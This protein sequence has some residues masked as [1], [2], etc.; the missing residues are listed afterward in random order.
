VKIFHG[1]PF[2]RVPAEIITPEIEGEIARATAQPAGQRS[3]RIQFSGQRARVP[4][5][6][7]EDVL[8]DITRQ[9]GRRN[10]SQR[11]GIDEVR[12][13]G[14]EFGER[15]FAAGFGVFAQELG[16]GLWLHLTH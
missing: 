4:C 5:E 14:D 10:L 15:G 11:R 2:A 6:A 3:V 8:G 13:S 9:I 7:G 1:L 12:V 16:I